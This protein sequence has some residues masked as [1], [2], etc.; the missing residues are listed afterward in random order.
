MA[1]RDCHIDQHQLDQHRPLLHRYLLRRTGDW[2][3]A[4][5]LVQETF[6]RLVVYARDHVVTDMAS[7]ARSIA[8]NLLNDHLRRR[9]R[10]RTEPISD[11]VPSPAVGV[12]EAAMQRQRVEA[13][14]RAL[15]GMPPLRREVFVRSRLR[16]QSYADIAAALGMSE[17]AVEKHVSRGL[18]WLQE[19][20]ARS[21]AAPPPAGARC[22][23]VRDPDQ[24]SEDDDA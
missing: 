6:L 1:S 24:R 13:F 2:S 16:G 15:Q 8:L 4:E 18:R 5:D 20:V 3:L 17:G 14:A 19:T 22:A 9:Q 21:D 7:L 12:E 23:A 11:E 10:Q